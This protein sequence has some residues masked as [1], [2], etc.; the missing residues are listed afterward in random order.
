MI[1]MTEKGPPGKNLLFPDGL[2]FCNLE[3]YIQAPSMRLQISLQLRHLFRQQPGKVNRPI[4]LQMIR[5]SKVFQIGLK[6]FVMG[7][8]T[9]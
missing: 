6:P 8:I 3:K 1:R 2:P 9:E 7:M 4:R 5:V